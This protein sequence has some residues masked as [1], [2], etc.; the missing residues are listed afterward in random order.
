MAQ[1]ASDQTLIN[2]AQHVGYEFEQIG[3]QTRV[4]LPFWRKGMLRVFVTHLSTYKEFAGNLQ[5]CLLTYGISCFVAHNDI[6]PTLEWQTEIETALATCDA[7]VALMHATFHTSNWTD[8][9]M[10]FAMGRGGD[11]LSNIWLMGSI[12]TG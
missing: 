2:L 4:D 10:G 1:G 8:Q 3:A 7:L 11:K 9:E 12:G 5:V 6:E